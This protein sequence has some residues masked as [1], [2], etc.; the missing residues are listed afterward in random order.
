M[1]SQLLVLDSADDRRELFALLSRLPPRDR[2]AFLRWCCSQVPRGRGRL[3]APS[4]HGYGGQVALAMRSDAEDGKLT[5]MVFVD[6]TTLLGEWG[7][8]ALRTA[9]ELEKRVRAMR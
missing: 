6:L 3:P 9:R 7:L 5:R 2:V 8:D 1:D 4:V